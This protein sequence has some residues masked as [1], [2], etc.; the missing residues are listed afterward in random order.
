MRQVSSLALL[1][2][3]VFAFL[4]GAVLGISRR[5]LSMTRSRDSRDLPGVPLVAWRRW[6]TIMAVAP[7]D[8]VGPRGRTG[9][10]GMDARRLR[11]VG[12]M[13]GA[14]KTVLNGEP[15]VW[16]GTW[17]S[18]LT[19]EKFLSSAP[20][21]YEALRRSARRMVP[22]VSGLV[23]RAVDGV[24]CSLSGLLGVGHLAGEEGVRSWVEDPAV[25]S[26]FSATTKKFHQCNGIF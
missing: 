17:R 22:R 9:M 19:A 4:G 21:Q 14:R 2:V 15:G 8:H 18:P 16:V 7:R 3:G 11:D 1:P 13:E 6:V 23:G 20:L 25:R 12:F 24:R 5:G 10:F 26:R